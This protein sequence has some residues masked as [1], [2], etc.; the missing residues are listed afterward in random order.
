MS[1]QP[2]KQLDPH[3]TICV[4][5]SKGREVGRVAATAPNA[6]AY[7]TE[8]AQH[9]GELE[10]EYVEDEVAAMVSNLLRPR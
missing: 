5:K 2:K 7:M 8:L 9:Y 3:K 10:V 6:S 4:C 1:D